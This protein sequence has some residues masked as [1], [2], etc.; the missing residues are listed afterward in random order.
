MIKETFNWLAEKPSSQYTLG[1]EKYSFRFNR[2]ARF[3]ERL[4]TIPMLAGGALIAAVGVPTGVIAGA[5]V[6]AGAM[7]VGGLIMAFAKVQGLV[8]GGIAHLIAQGAS[9]LANRLAEKK[10]A[11]PPAPDNKV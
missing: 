11:Q 8:H 4:T 2:A 3:V 5:P 9:G 1:G 6:V 7:V 10:A